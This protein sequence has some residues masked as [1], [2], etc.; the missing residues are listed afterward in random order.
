[1]IK[2]EIMALRNVIHQGIIRLYE[3]IQERDKLILVM[4]LVNGG[5][6]YSLIKELKKV[7]ER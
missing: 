6:L 1:M 7:P 2:N 5:D 3:V 4:E